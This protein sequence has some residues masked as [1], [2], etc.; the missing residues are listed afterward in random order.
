VRWLA[1]LEI[2]A[3]E[4]ALSDPTEMEG[5]EAELQLRGLE[6]IAR[7]GRTRILSDILNYLKER[8]KAH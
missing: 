1:A 2:W 5:L 6:T 7:G 4:P 3:K 8:E